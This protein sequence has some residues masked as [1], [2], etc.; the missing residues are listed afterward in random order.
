MT[1]AYPRLRS[2][3]RKRKN[4]SIVVYYFYDMRLSGK[5]DVPLGTDY[6]EAIRRWR[7]LHEH[8]PRIKGTLMEAFEAWERDVLPTYENAGTKRT[9][10]QNLR[11]LKPI[12]GTSTWDRVKLPHLKAYLKQRS[13]KTQAN[14]EMA[15]LSIIWNW[16]RLEGL[17]ELPWPAAGMEKARWRNKE[18]ARQ[19]EVSDALFSAIYE[20]ADTVLRDCM[21][22]ATATGMRLTDCRTVLMPTGDELALRASKTGKMV[23]FDIKESAV[24]TA[25]VER[26][27][28]IKASHLMLL[29][30]PTGKPV[31]ATM[32]RD[33]YDAARA[34][35]AAKSENAE[36]VDQIKAMFLR[37]MRK[38]AA[39]LAGDLSE[40]SRLL[41]HSS[42]AVTR[43]HYRTRPVKVKPVR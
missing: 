19:F 25:L 12:F 26:R 33:R 23:S 30:T 10:A 16:A 40:A 29:T 13:A 35:A 18:Q 37:D 43:I 7:V 28:A 6:E 39:D 11:T 14:R 4:G 24:L 22:L 17:H 31:S 38:R 34:K 1:N 21:D 8:I 42:E 3:V 27:R 15:L 32:L 36:I 41:Q 2:H 9:Y 5:P 20:A